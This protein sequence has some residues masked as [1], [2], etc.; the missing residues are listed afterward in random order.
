M[1]AITPYASPALKKDTAKT[2]PTLRASASAKVDN[3]IA[4]LTLTVPSTA[5]PGDFVVFAI[6]SSSNTCSTPTGLTKELVTQIP[7]SSN[8]PYLHI[9]SRRLVAGDVSSD[10]G[11][12]FTF[13]AGASDGLC[14]GLQVFADTYGFGTRPSSTFMSTTDTTNGHDPVVSSLHMGPNDLYAGCA[15]AIPQTGIGHANAL[16]DSAPDGCT[17][18]ENVYALRAGGELASVRGFAMWTGPTHAPAVDEL[19]YPTET[20]YC[21][22]VV[23]SLAP[24]PPHMVD[25]N[26]GP[27]SLDGVPVYNYSNSSGSVVPYL[28]SDVSRGA[29]TYRPWPERIQGAFGQPVNSRNMAMGGARAA[30]I[31]TAAYGTATIISTRAGANNGSAYTNQRVSQAVT[32]TALANRLT[33]LYTTD[34]VGNDFFMLDASDLT[35]RGAYNAVQALLRLIRAGTVYGRGAG[36][37]TADGTWS[38]VSSTG[39]LGG[40]ASKTTTPGG[41][42]TIPLTDVDAIDVVLIG[43]DDTAL[44]VT[45]APFTIKVDGVTHTPAA[46]FALTNP[47]RTISLGAT[48]SNQM[49]N[50]GVYDD[51]KFCQMVIPITGIGAGSHTV[52]IEHAGGS[53][54]LIYNGYMIPSTT[55][56]WIVT[57]CIWIFPDV[58]YT[59]APMGYASAALGKQAADWF[60][61]VVRL[62]AAQFTD[63]VILYDPS[64]S[65]RWNPAVHVSAGDLIHHSELGVSLY[66]REIIRKL[67]ERIASPYT[68]P[69]NPTSVSPTTLPATFTRIG[70][71][72]FVVPAGVTSLEIE[73]EGPGGGGGGGSAG[74]FGPGRGGGGGAYAKK[75]SVAVTPGETLRVTVGPG[76]AGGAVAGVGSAGVASKVVRLSDMSELCK[77]ASGSGGGTTG[78]T[79]GAGGTTAASTGDVKTAGTAASTTSGGA[80]AAPLG[81]AGATYVGANSGLE[82]GTPGGGGSAGNNSHTGGPGG[83]GLV[84]L[85]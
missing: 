28:P 16:L 61:Q 1:S 10:Y 63:R 37:Q 41:K 84:K 57:N 34:L 8:Q 83:P 18:N 7:D 15:G 23:Y 72:D 54:Q 5:Q 76:G 33:A 48:T 64:E 58:A 78:G 30:D 11:V 27:V 3:G 80:G 70:T 24:L 56:P 9:Y 46:S 79:V 13:T 26:R 21:T 42:I 69:T 51:Y 35:L 52:T 14:G 17:I 82:G 36:G 19:V 55:P 31:C 2:T 20:I 25:T 12:S 44:S 62:I 32:Q 38:D 40:V 81:A 66:A 71:R 73:C 67:N 29:N 49:Q 77:A 50:T 85:T 47:A 59:S 6:S 39:Y 68:P 75:N 22:S 74:G 53:G 45:G 65:G 60:N 43:Y 4:D